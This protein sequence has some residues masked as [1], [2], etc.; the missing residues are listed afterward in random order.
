L[1]VVVVAPSR[2]ND[3]I[4]TVA[5]NVSKGADVARKV[6]VIR[7]SRDHPDS[8]LRPNRGKKKS[9][10]KKGQEGDLGDFHVMKPVGGL[11]KVRGALAERRLTPCTYDGIPYGIRGK[12]FKEIRFK[13]GLARPNE[14]GCKS[15]WQEI[16]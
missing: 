8:S 9:G 13:A 15:N 7:V 2:N 4:K 1:A 5:V 16:R 12:E 6:V 3:F 10:G 14:V 11:A